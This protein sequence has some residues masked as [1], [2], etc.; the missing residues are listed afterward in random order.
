MSVFGFYFLFLFFQ[1]KIV[2]QSFSIQSSFTQKVRL[3]QIRSLTEDLRFYYKRLR[4][5]KDELEPRR[6][7]KVG[8]PAE[9]EEKITML[10]CVNK[11]YFLYFN[12]LFV[13]F[14]FFFFFIFQVANIYF[15]AGLQCGDHCYVGLP[16]VLKCKFVFPFVC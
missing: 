6:K 15:D 14:F 16:F 12:F 8:N 11:T 10:V 5:N 1:G 4:N 3:Q 9:V 13:S 2:H 7:S